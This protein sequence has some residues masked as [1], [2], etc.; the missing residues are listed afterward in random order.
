MTPEEGSTG[1]SLIFLQKKKKDKTKWDQYLINLKINKWKFKFIVF[2][3]RCPFGLGFDEA[4]LLCNWP[5]L[6]PGCGGTGAVGGSIGSGSGLGLG[7]GLGS[8][9]DRAGKLLRPDAN[10]G[11]NRQQVWEIHWL[12]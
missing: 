6:V 2:L 3:S 12:G 1:T 8:G 11:I 5:W 10:R 9:A 7:S 4:N